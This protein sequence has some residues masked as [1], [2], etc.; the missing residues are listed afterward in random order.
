LILVK[1][2]SLEGLS[3]RASDFAEEALVPVK[4]WEFLRRHLVE[5]VP[6]EMSSCL[7][8]GAVQCRDEQYATCANRLA[9]EAA[10]RAAPPSDR[11]RP[12]RTDGEAKT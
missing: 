2:T 8:C 1:Y 6:D 3:V 7:D 5:E 10:L 11:H 4:L 9:R 12:D